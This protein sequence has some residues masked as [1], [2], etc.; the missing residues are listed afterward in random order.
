[1]NEINLKQLGWKLAFLPSF[2]KW[3]K[4]SVID[5]QKDKLETLE[6]ENKRLREILKLTEKRLEQT[7][8]EHEQQI[9]QILEDEKEDITNTFLYLKYLKGLR[10]VRPQKNDKIQDVF[11][12]AKCFA[13]L[14]YPWNYPA[15]YVDKIKERIKSN[16]EELPNSAKRY[17]QRYLYNDKDMVLIRMDSD[18]I[19]VG[20]YDSRELYEKEK[21]GKKAEISDLI[22]DMAK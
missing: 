5:F 21:M 20:L 13:E 8:K 12:K 4:K 18:G 11:P 9:K 3:Y 7:E 16:T 10:R 22:A 17:I 6:K 1:M 2:R 15:K 14:T 19:Y